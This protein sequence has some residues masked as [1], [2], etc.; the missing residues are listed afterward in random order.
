MKIRLGQNEATISNNSKRH[1]MMKGLDG[2]KKLCVNVKNLLV[3]KN[4]SLQ[5]SVVILSVVI[6][7]KFVIAVIISIYNTCRNL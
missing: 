3:L 1:C 5:F 6:V 2:L 7:S 4:L